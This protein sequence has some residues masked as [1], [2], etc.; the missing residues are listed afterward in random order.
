MHLW[1]KT[2]WSVSNHFWYSKTLSL[3]RYLFLDLMN[4]ND[5]RFQGHYTFNDVLSSV[6]KHT[7]TKLF[8]I[9]HKYA[10]GVYFEGEA[11]ANGVGWVGVGCVRVG[12][13]GVELWYMYGVDVCGVCGGARIGSESED[14]CE[15][16]TVKLRTFWQTENKIWVFASWPI[17]TIYTLY[18]KFIKHRW[19]IPGKVKL[20]LISGK[21]SPSLLDH[22]SRFVSHQ[23]VTWYLRSISK[24]KLW[25]FSVRAWVSTWSISKMSQ[26]WPKRYTK[27]SQTW[28]N[29][30]LY[31]KKSW[32]KNFIRSRWN[33]KYVVRHLCIA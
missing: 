25:S 26:T 5:A 2:C 13:V 22:I 21:K 9:L 17:V 33:C 32:W 14:K 29:K 8:V 20:L 30:I 4:T 15:Y 28:P 6:K 24:T 12:C 7:T 18:I 16:N 19:P 11:F 23:F 1:I 31:Q 27:M 10:E 3:F